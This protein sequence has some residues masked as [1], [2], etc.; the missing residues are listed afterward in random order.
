MKIRYIII[1]IIIFLSLSN[2]SAQVEQKKEIDSLTTLLRTKIDDTTRVIIYYNLQNIYQKFD[3]VAQESNSKKILELSKKIKYKK[4]YGLYY[5]SLIENLQDKQQ[6]VEALNY[7]K[8]AGSI[9]KEINET[10]LYLSALN[11]EA[12]VYFAKN[13]ISKAKKIANIGLLHARGTKFYRNMGTLHY[14]LA[15]CYIADYQYDNALKS[16]NQAIY[17]FRNTRVLDKVANCYY[18]MSS[19]YFESNNLPKALQYIKRAIA[20]VDQQ[21]VF[22]EQLNASYYLLTSLIYQS[23]KDNR[24][25][26]YFISKAEKIYRKAENKALLSDALVILGGIYNDT[27]EYTIAIKTAKEI[28]KINPEYFFMSDVYELL[29]SSYLGLGNYAQAKFYFK[30][31]ISFRTVEN[32]NHEQDSNMLPLLNSMAQLEYALENYKEALDYKMDYARIQRKYLSDEKTDL[33]SELQTKF[34]AKET[35][36]SLQKLEVLKQ[37]KEIELTKQTVYVRI[38]TVILLSFIMLLGTLIWGYYSIIRKNQLLLTK[39]LIVEKNNHQLEEASDVIKNSLEEKE[40]L[41]KELHHR[42]KNNLQ[43]IMSL[44]SIQARETSDTDI[45]VFLE[46]GRSRITSMAYIHQNLYENG[47]VGKVNYQQY[48]NNLISSLHSA[49]TPELE[50]VEMEVE[51]CAQYFEMQTAI[52]LGLII[53][54]LVSNAF[55]HA[56]PNNRKGKI[57]IAISE[58]QN[59]YFELCISDNGIGIY[60]AEKST[61]SLGMKIVALLVSQIKGTICTENR[62]G[63]THIINFNSTT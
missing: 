7:A 34:D 38:T 57:R 24:Q 36:Y 26:I 21:N 52:P 55:K 39:N 22:D 42:V 20:T 9:Y 43:M 40:L 30:K 25:S 29:G 15:C 49:L 10:A 58:K 46:K 59:G 27:K 6:Y 13:D 23:M 62:S 56:F 5:S 1:F 54:E 37:K 47:Q 2:V 18:A 53:N 33:I 60:A 12:M 44:L 63:T 3:K 61:R 51:V 28:I 17:F 19:I 48:I 16:L 41:I 4:G 35:A 50:N 14:T 45:N 11:V 32:K 31:S 8:K